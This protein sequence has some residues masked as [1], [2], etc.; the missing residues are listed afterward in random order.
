MKPGQSSSEPVKYILSCLW[1]FWPALKVTFLIQKNSIQVGGG[2]YLLWA[3]ENFQEFSDSAE[4][5]A[6]SEVRGNKSG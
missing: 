5:I 2:S 1:V 4:K 6:D 3:I